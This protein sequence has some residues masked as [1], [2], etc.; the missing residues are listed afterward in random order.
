M[1]IPSR[2]ALRSAPHVARSNDRILLWSLARIAGC[3]AAFAAFTASA[4][5][6][7]VV[8]PADAQKPPEKKPTSLYDQAL[9]TDQ[10]PSTTV[11]AKR[12][13]DLREEDLV[14]PYNQPEWTTARR[15]P[16]T[17]VYVR[18]PE[19]VAFEYWLIPLF[20]RH[21][22]TQ[23]KTQYEVEIGLPEHFQLDVYMT[24]NSDGQKGDF[25]FNEQ[26]V[27]LRWAFADWNAIPAN[28]TLY[29]EYTFGDKEPDA[30]EGKLLL[31][32][33]IS[34][35]WHWGLNLVYERQISGDLENTYELTGG[36][37]H[38]LSDQRFSLGAEIKTSLND[39]H[40]SRGDFDKELLIG[41]SAQ[42]RAG[43]H[44]HVDLAPLIGIGGESPAA[45]IYLVAGYEF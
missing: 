28:P 23:T 19:T 31:G 39:V 8:N 13:S 7:Q 18:P 2:S 25:G 33:E 9:Q 36:I 34:S 37:S 21:G 24:S 26:S 29:L 27:E 45:Q 3:S 11:T 12:V 30:I 40:G 10:V 42:Y 20:P 5:I 38:T 32:D 4:T 6:A 1:T 35:G 44:V 16:S 15:F 22:A 14:G 17:R 41:P 43:S